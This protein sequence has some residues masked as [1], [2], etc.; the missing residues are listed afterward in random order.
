MQTA[1]VTTLSEDEYPLWDTFVSGTER[2]T[3]FHRSGWGQIISRASDR[4][5]RILACRRGD[6]IL[7]GMCLFDNIKLGFALATP[8][9]MFPFNG[10]LIGTAT[11]AGEHKIIARMMKYSASF[12]RFLTRHYSYWILDT[13]PGF[14]DVRIFQWAGCHVEPVYTYKVG[15]K[16]DSISDHYNQSARRK[17]KE[18]EQLKIEVTESDAIGNFTDLYEKSYHRHNKRPPVKLTMIEKLLEM[19]IRL[20]E[21]RLYIA[22]DGNRVIAG[23]IVVEDQKCVYDLLAGGDD[24]T[25]L[26]AATIIHRLLGKY[27]NSHEYF[28]FM[29]AGHQQ[30]EQFKRGF[31][32]YL[33]MGFRISNRPGFPVS[34]MVNLHN[35]NIARRRKL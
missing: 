27:S 9:P 18:S 15:L 2:G 29:G 7:A 13:G 21:V 25:G 32:G 11:G 17:I 26:G 31:G 10:P 14:Y 8:V 30:I 3:F 1:D 6:E 12:I 22:R 23:R 24:D 28:D 4:P 35:A 34:L 33:D 16:K 20:P 5:L 19:I